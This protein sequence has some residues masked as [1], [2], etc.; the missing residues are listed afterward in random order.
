MHDHD[1]LTSPGCCRCAPKLKPKYTCW[2]HQ[3]LHATPSCLCAEPSG[4]DLDV[5]YPFFVLQTVWNGM[6]PY[7]RNHRHELLLCKQVVAMETICMYIIL[8]TEV[9][10]QAF[11]GNR[12]LQRP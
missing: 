11:H 7:H 9:C 1:A 3:H 10:E 2:G 4:G 12:T 8:S 6:T 5:L